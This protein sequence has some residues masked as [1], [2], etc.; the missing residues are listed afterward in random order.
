MK[1]L[2]KKVQTLWFRNMHFDAGMFIMVEKCSR[3]S[4]SGMRVW[5]VLKVR[6]KHSLFWYKSYKSHDFVK[7]I[8]L[9]TTLHLLLYM[10]YVFLVYRLPY[11]ACRSCQFFHSVNVKHTWTSRA[12]C[13]GNRLDFFHLWPSVLLSIY[14]FLCIYIF[15]WLIL[16]F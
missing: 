7:Y 6:K 5:N 4:V 13:K 9:E 2:I 15:K 1:G 16:R 8:P 12:S 10:Q 11:I 14:G 3:D